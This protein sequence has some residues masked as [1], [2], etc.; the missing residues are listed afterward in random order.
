VD[1]GNAG[2]ARGAAFRPPLGNMRW[3][4]GGRS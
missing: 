2:N 1:I 4:V 3:V